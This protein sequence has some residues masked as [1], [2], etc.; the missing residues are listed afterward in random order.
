MDVHDGLGPDHADGTQTMWEPPGYDADAGHTDT[1]PDAYDGQDTSGG[2]EDSGSGGYEPD[3]GSGEHAGTMTVEVEGQTRELPAE[4]DYTGD[5]QADAAVE[6][7][8]GKV[9]VF[10]D[11][12]DNE[13][14]AAGPDGKADEAYIVDKETGQVVGTAHVDPSSGGWVDGADPDGP[15]AVGSGGGSGTETGTGGSGAE[16]GS[17]G[18]EDQGGAGTETTGGGGQTPGVVTVEADG[19][20]IGVAKTIDT[21]GDG[22]AD[23]GVL[24]TDGRAVVL[25]DTDGDPEAEQA[26]IIDPETGQVVEVAHVDPQTGEWEEG[27]ATSTGGTG[28]ETGTETGTGT[29]G[30]TG[31]ETT[32]TTEGT[33]GSMSVEVNG[34]TQ[35]LPTERDYTGDGQ[36]DA[37]VETKDGQ[38]IVF[39]D[40]ENNETGAAGPDGKADEAWIVDK[41]T[42]RVVGA[43]HVDP[44]TGEWVDGADTDGPSSV[45]SGASS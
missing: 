43:A 5:G 39:A 27:P 38:V 40:T 6:T 44:R 26:T 19:H 7:S 24:Y 18:Y 35:N 12:E 30:T 41:S 28:T 31:T 32:G 17:G 10:A 29:T 2:Y 15:S 25:T 33:T 8:D 42:G 3:G 20:E 37:A 16:T 11:T 13:T 14:G 34:E 45:P 9:I 1:A 22:V 21:D 4:R 36:A 23:S